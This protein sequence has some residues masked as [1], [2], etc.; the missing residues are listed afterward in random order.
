MALAKVS[1]DDKYDLG[2]ERIYVSGSQAVVRLALMQHAIDKAN[3]LNTAGYVTGYRGSPVGGIDQTFQRAGRFLKQHSVVF[4]PGLNEDLAATALWGSQQAELRGEG[5]FDGVFGIWYGKGPGVDRSGDVFRHA[6]HAGTSRH[7]GVLALMGDDHTCESSTSAHQSEFAFVDAMIPVL[8]PSNVQELLDYGIYGFALSRFS[9]VWVGLKCVKDNIEQ[10]AVTDGRIDRVK[11][12]IPVDFAMPEG[13]LNIRLHDTPLAKEARLHD[14]KR[15]S[16]LAFT[17]AN[18]LDRIILAGGR[19]PRIGIITAGKSYQDV[20]EALDMLGI[21]EVR[22]AD[23]GIRLY[24]VAVTYPLEPQ[25]VI[26]FAE[27]LDLVIVVE[28]KRALIE[29]QIKEE[30]YGKTNAPVIVGKMDETGKW[31]FPAK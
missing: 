7:G 12:I 19:K 18:G 1:L 26:A 13:G 6:N 16:I 25:G 20:A 28:E 23:L 22:A 8:N 2:Q 31:L 30:L 3:G 5:K 10:T 24:K 17:R 27:G 29:V 14:Y 11:P 15:S 9:G 4:Q 21:D